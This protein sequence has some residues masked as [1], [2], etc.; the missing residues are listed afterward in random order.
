MSRFS[1]QQAVRG[2]RVGSDEVQLDAS[3][4]DPVTQQISS[5]HVV[6]TEDGIRLYPVKLRYAWP[7]E[8]DL[9]ARL[10]GLQLRHRW[11]SWR[12]D[13][14]AADSGKHISVFGQA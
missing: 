1:G 13:P 4:L 2:I 12:K 6:L 5:Q 8:F 7:A 9:M 3:Q 11:A 10:A 14:F